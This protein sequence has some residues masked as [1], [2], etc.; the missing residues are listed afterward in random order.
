MITNLNSSQKKGFIF[1]S[2]A[3]ELKWH[4]NKI[5][6]CT[7]LI[8]SLFMHCAWCWS[9]QAHTFLDI[10]DLEKAPKLTDYANEWDWEAQ[11][12]VVHWCCH[13]ARLLNLSKPNLLK[14]VCMYML[15]CMPVHVCMGFLMWYNVVLCHMC[16]YV[17]V[18]EQLWSGF[19]SCTFVWVP[20]IKLRLSGLYR[21]VAITF[22]H[23]AISL[24]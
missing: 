14:V 9:R 10:N 16:T 23:W 19:C 11:V 24:P 1:L 13:F 15:I 12:G 17:E 22:T 3:L 4:V 20:G 18:R 2:R 8:K 6:T 7:Q 5:R 21:W